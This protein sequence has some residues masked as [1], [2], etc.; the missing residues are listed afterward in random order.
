MKDD[1][2]FFYYPFPDNRRVHM[3]VKREAG[4]VWFRMWNADDER[5]WE[6]HGWVPHGA[7]LKAAEIYSGKS[8]D[9]VRAYDLEIA[10]ALLAEGP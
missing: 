3:Y 10:N 5:L 4:V 1:R 8:F 2:G 9:P 6:E 7:I